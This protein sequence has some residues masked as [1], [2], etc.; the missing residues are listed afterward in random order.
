MRD[1]RIIGVKIKKEK[2]KKFGKKK[3]RKY[4]K[5]ARPGPYHLQGEEGKRGIEEPFIGISLH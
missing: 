2:K 3:E 4:K 5:K 1:F